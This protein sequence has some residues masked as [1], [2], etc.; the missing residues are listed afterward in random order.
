MIVF[1]IVWILHHLITTFYNRS[2]KSYV[3]V[4]VHDWL[5]T[6]SKSILVLIAL[7]YNYA[8]DNTP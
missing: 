1:E 5:Q 4:D 7:K 6:H 2:K 8:M 3:K